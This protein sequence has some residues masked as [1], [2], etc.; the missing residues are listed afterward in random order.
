MEIVQLEN[1]EIELN[2][3]LLRRL[4]RSYSRMQGFE[5]EFF[6]VTDSTEQKL[7]EAETSPSG[8][9]QTL[10]QL[11]EVFRSIPTY[12]TFESRFSGNDTLLS[13]DRS[14]SIM[15]AEMAINAFEVDS[16]RNQINAQ[17]VEIT[18]TGKVPVMGKE[19]VLYVERMVGNY[20]LGSA[21][22]DEEGI[23]IMEIPTDIPGGLTGVINMILKL[24]DDD[25]GT[26]QY[27]LEKPWGIP[28]VEIELENQRTLWTPDPPYWML[29]IFL[30]ILIGIWLHYILIFRDLFLVSKIVQ[31]KIDKSVTPGSS[32]TLD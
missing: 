24:E 16:A 1:K 22:T 4:D 19:I 3:T 14:A 12:L 21:E 25:Y 8:I 2:A 15:L 29:T 17:L 31:P 7:D 6:Y 9:A 18:D 27:S 11:D 32:D 23:A 20:S 13:S 28:I 30:A 10:V 5:V 26:I